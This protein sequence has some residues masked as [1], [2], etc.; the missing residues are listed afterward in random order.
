MPQQNLTET[1]QGLVRRHGLS[2]VLHSLAD[3]QAAPDQDTS[4]ISRK[5]SFNTGSKLS[6]VN[7]VEKMTLPQEK[8]EVMKCAAQRFEDGGFLPSIADIRE[9]CRIH[10]VELGKSASRVS[11]IP[12]LFTFLAAMDTARIAKLL[13]E[14]AFSGPTRLAPVADAIRNRSTVRSHKH[15]GQLAQMASDATISGHS[16]NR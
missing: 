2:S 9:F 16:K 12:R 7:Y 13:N 8:A 1:L 6:A 14:G 11:S 5:R 4:S 10:D 3:I 15:A